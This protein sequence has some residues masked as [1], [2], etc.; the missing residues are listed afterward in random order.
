M[1]PL[2]R[3][4][5]HLVTLHPKL[6]AVP[7]LSGF[8]S[9]V[10]PVPL[11][12]GDI[13]RDATRYVDFSFQNMHNAHMAE[14]DYDDALWDLLFGPH[15]L[16]QAIEV[17][18]QA[19]CLGAVSILLFTMIDTLASLV[20][21][22]GKAQ[23]GREAFK[24]WVSRYLRIPGDNVTTPTDWYSARC[25]TLHTYG[26]VSSHTESKKARM[27]CWAGAMFPHVIFNP[28]IS[29]DLIVVDVEAFKV[30]V[31]DGADLFMLKVLSDPQSATLARRRAGWLLT[32]R[33]GPG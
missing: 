8:P 18:W 7:S 19:E 12:P 3:G 23:V 25:A 14:A 17:V 13:Y 31:F 2:Y 26:T 33:P 20:R 29:E 11:F 24:D 30:A 32:H 21:P 4:A 15:G 22:E 28:S 9:R 5:C 1:H 10:S 6:G 16:R 27:I